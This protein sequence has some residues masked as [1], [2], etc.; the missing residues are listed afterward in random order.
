ME[1][2]SSR[3]PF[4]WEGGAGGQVGRDYEIIGDPRSSN[5]MSGSSPSGSTR[6]EWPL[7]P[8]PTISLLQV[9]G[10]EVYNGTPVSIKQ[11]LYIFITS[12]QYYSIVVCMTGGFRWSVLKSYDELAYI[13]KQV[14]THT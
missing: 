1:F 13:N 9:S 4:H 14:H 3:K 2:A 6:V 5:N 7:F 10:Y 11:S 12:L 8:T